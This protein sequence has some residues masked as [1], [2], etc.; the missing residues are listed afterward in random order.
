LSNPDR[1][2][3]DTV[4]TLVNQAMY[5]MPVLNNDDPITL[6]AVRTLIQ[7]ACDRAHKAGYEAATKDKD[8]EF[9]RRE[10]DLL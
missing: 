9:E 10:H 8:E 3:Q 2:N 6:D 7:I 1:D 5:L 4:P